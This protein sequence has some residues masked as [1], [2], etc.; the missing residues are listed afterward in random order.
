[1]TT[2]DMD[3]A[4]IDLANAAGAI[5]ERYGLTA[6]ALFYVLK[7]VETQVSE[8]RVSELLT[9]PETAEEQAEEPKKEDETPGVKTIKRNS[10]SLDA[11]KAIIAEK[12][13]AGD[14][15]ENGRAHCSLREAAERTKA[16]DSSDN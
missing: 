7:K 13:A 16:D 8:A 9:A 4:S 5:A 14:V 11:V 15:D 1:M 12:I 2:I 3:R 6:S 10:A